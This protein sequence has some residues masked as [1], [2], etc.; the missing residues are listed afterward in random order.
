[1]EMQSAV[2]YTRPSLGPPRERNSTVARVQ[3]TATT[4]VGGVGL[5]W[6][7][8]ACDNLLGHQLLRY[9]IRAWD[10]GGLIG[11]PFA[12]F[13]HDGF[14]HLTMNTLTFVILGA[15]IHLRRPGDFVMVSVWG[16]LGSGL[17]AWLLSPPNVTTVGL[18]G[19]L[20]AYLGFLM[21]RGFFERRLAAMLLSVF[22]TLSFGSMLLGVLPLVAT[23]ISWQAHLAGFIAG[24]ACAAVARPR[25][26]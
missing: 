6:I 1:M 12:P 3:R 7:V 25:R 19:V 17:G 23:G 26:G 14:V 2:R 11:I 22:V 21:T 10:W 20:F 9:G 13:L 5:L 4:V 24:V 16:A 8:F 15:L 18:S